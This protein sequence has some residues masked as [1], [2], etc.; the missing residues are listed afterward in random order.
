MYPSHEEIES[1]IRKAHEGK[2]QR[3]RNPSV[4]GVNEK[5]STDGAAACPCRHSR[6]CLEKKGE[7]SV[8]LQNERSQLQGQ[9]T[10]TDDQE[11]TQVTHAQ[12]ILERISADGQGCDRNAGEELR[13]RTERGDR[14][15]SISAHLTLY[16]SSVC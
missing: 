9:G 2:G 8:V 16:A 14:N 11:R 4:A 10:R 15:W 7:V 13:N 6:H 5:D 1:N 12:S 3:G